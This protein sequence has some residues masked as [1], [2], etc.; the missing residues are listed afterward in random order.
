[1]NEVFTIRVRQHC[2]LPIGSVITQRH[3]RLIRIVIKGI[4]S[5]MKLTDKSFET[6]YHQ[7]ETNVASL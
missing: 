7:T 6:I 5:G 2:A 3:C 4:Y 1:M